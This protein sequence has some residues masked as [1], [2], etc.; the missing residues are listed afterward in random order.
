M[1]S[2][3]NKIFNLDADPQDFNL[4]FMLVLAACIL[5]PMGILFYFFG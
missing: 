1:K 3:L 2:I 4:Q 5:T